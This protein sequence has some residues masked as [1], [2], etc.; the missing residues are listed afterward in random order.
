MKNKFKRSFFDFDDD[1]DND[2][3]NDI[4][5]NDETKTNEK[6]V[7]HDINEKEKKHDF[8]KN[9][10]NQKNTITKIADEKSM[11]FVTKKK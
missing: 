4:R 2:D 9:V 1:D 5:N 7:S 10:S 3:D 6:N 8:V 11:K